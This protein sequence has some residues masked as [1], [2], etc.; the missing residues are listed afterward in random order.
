[1]T[2]KPEAARSPKARR[3]MFVRRW[4]GAAI[5]IAAAGIVALITVTGGD[6]ATGLVLTV[7]L[8][9]A[10]WLVSP[11]LFPRGPDWTTAQ[12]LAQTRGVPLILWKPGCAYCIRLR[13]TL[14]TAGSRAIWVD[15]WADENAA[16]A[17]RS[18]NDGNETTPTVIT[19]DG[20]RTN[21]Q[22]GW[23]KAQLKTS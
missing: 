17:T 2:P 12:Q 10:G 13:L 16:A 15:I 20:A 3:A 22:P 21:P 18:L 14:G 8:L 23:V 6:R 19:A 11:V 7:A 1:M 5:A 9:V 4:R